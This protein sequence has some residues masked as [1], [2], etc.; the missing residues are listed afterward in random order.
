MRQNFREEIEAGLLTSLERRITSDVLSDLIQ[1]AR[2]ALKEAGDSVLLHG[3]H[4][5]W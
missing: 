2:A 4:S 3:A 5:L 1:P